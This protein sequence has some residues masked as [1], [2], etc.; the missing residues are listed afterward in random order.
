MVSW[1]QV[2]KIQFFTDNGKNKI[3]VNGQNVCFSGMECMD[4]YADC[5]V[6]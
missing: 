3:I 4:Q 1:S 6:V 5:M 2:E